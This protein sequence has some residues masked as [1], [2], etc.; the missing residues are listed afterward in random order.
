MSTV[1]LS[2]PRLGDGIKRPIFI[3]RITWIWNLAAMFVWKDHI[4]DPTL[5]ILVGFT[6]RKEPS[7]AIKISKPDLS[8]IF[9][10]REKR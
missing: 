5:W 4:Y 9:R 3:G 1:R 7:R 6:V 2:P 10:K 8:T